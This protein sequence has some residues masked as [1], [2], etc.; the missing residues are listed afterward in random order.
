MDLPV[1]SV[2]AIFCFLSHFVPHTVVF[3]F[4]FLVLLLLLLVFDLHPV[5]LIFADKATV[6]S[7]HHCYINTA[8]RRLLSNVRMATVQDKRTKLKSIDLVSW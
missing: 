1:L 6:S 7:V 3:V 4:V 2:L 5:L 8:I